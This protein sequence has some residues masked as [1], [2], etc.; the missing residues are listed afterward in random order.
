MN[1]SELDKL[2]QSDYIPSEVERRRAVM[3][4]LFIWLV[5]SLIKGLKSDYEKYHF[6]QA[7]WWWFLFFVTLLISIVFLFIPFIK[8]LPIL[9][10]LFLIVVS[11]IFVN[12]AIT[13]KYTLD[14]DKILFPVFYWLWKWVW[15][16]F[17]IDIDND[18]ENNNE[19]KWQR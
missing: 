15:D 19:N 2:I 4:Y 16:L 5:I 7:M 17:D 6:Y 11:W 10:I 3:M 14:K 13:W 9:F 1:S 8:F 18:L 12:Q